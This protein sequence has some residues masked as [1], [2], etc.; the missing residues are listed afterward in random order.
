[1]RSELI[2]FV[3]SRTLFT[4]D[5]LIYYHNNQPF[6]TKDRDNDKWPDNCAEHQQGAF[7]HGSGCGYANLNGKY[8][9]NGVNRNTGVWW[10]TW[11]NNVYSLKRVEMKI[12]P[13]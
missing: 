6:T 1:M 9:R 13:N 11:K 10:H 12:K 2:Y 4:G 5:S 8:W 7:W 3:K